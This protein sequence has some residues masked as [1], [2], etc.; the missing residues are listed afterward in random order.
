[1]SVFSRTF[2]SAAGTFVAQFLGGP[3]VGNGPSIPM[4]ALALDID[5]PVSEANPLPTGDAATQATLASVL[6]KISGDPA[7]QATLAAVL[8]KL[9]ADPATAAKQD[10]LATALA[11]V[12]AGVVSVDG[13]VDGLETTS[14]AIL[15]KL[16][17]D[18]ATQVTL[19][20]VLAKLSSD[21]AT[22][23]TLAAALAAIQAA[24]P[25]GEN[26]IGAVG[27]HTVV[28]AQAV[29]GS[30]TAYTAGDC[31]GSLL[32][33]AGLG[34]VAGGTGLVQMASVM[35][36]TAQTADLDL[37][38]FHTNPSAS[39]FTDNAALAVNAADWDKVIDVV[40]I[41]D[42]TSLGTPSFA[43]ATALAV[44][45]KVAAGQTEI[46]GQLVARG[47]FTLSSASDLKVAVKGMLD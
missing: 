36:K 41:T 33:F 45:Y 28:V 32:T 43:K 44:A 10:A 35:S 47:A 34:R 25:A 26:H 5:T 15:A 14:S 31:V 23:T 19:A 24:T 7:T 37:V 6:A 22:Q 9:S 17:G 13:H 29:V 20:A 27:G 38:L 11:T 18:P 2:R 42:W 1:M 4:Q 39:T 16:S 3:S 30:T 40:H 8:A 12:I 21:P 46:Y